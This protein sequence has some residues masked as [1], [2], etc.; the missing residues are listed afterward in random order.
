MGSSLVAT[1]A[2][3]PSNSDDGDEDDRTSESGTRVILT[4]VVMCHPCFVTCHPFSSTLPILD[5]QTFFFL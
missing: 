2:V 4:F 5:S 3:V 1:I